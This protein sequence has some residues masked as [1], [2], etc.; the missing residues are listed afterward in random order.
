VY[1]FQGTYCSSTNKQLKKM[2][3]VCPSETVVTT[4]YIATAH[5]REKYS[6]K[7][8]ALENINPHSL[9]PGARGGAVG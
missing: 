4:Q 2:E 9:I 3:A 7:L 6:K 1:S 8:Q 5:H